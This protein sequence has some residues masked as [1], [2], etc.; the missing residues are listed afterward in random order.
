MWSLRETFLDAPNTIDMHSNS[1]NFVSFGKWMILLKQE[2]GFFSKREDLPLPE[3][4]NCH[5]GFVVWTDFHVFLVRDKKH[6]K[7]EKDS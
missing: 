1:L 3:V 2:D 6:Y 4:Y 5:N 7:I